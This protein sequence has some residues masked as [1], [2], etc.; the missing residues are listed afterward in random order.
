MARLRI[1]IIGAGTIAQVEHIPN[2]VALAEKFE[3]HGVA[4]PSKTARDF[5]EHTYGLP[6]FDTAGELLQLALD[7]VI[8]CSPD[9]LHHEHVLAA[10]AAG[11]HVFCEK[12]LCYSVE[13]IDEIIAQRDAAGKCVQVG[14]MKRFDV[15]YETALTRMPGSKSTLRFVSVEVNDPDAWPFIAHYPTNFGKDV[16]AALVEELRTKQARQI[17]SAVKAELDRVG[18]RGFAAAFCSSLVHDV[19][20]VHGVLDVLGV[21]DGRIVGAHLFANGDGGHGAVSLLDGQA[22]WSMCHLTVP[23]LADYK[24]RISFYFDDAVLELEYS[25]PWLHHQPTRLM[26]KTSDGHLL[27]KTELRAG[28]ESAYMRELVGFWDA[29]VNGSPVR[30]SAEHARRDQKLLCGL[31]ARHA[32]E[33]GRAS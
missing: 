14:Y 20:A 5:V 15:N 32:E 18:A 30:N 27:E 12:P 1:G 6:V 25:S 28:F 29:C 11:L 16:P 23:A 10:L 3:V 4:D 31:A 26:I 17:R 13:E 2:A 19:N 9:P 22:L 33:R 8:V 21:P 7:A 24:E